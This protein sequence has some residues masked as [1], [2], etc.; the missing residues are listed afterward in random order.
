MN[1]SFESNNHALTSV[2]KYKIKKSMHNHVL[3]NCQRSS[4]SDGIVG[5]NHNAIKLS[6]HVINSSALTSRPYHASAS[7]RTEV[8]AGSSVL[9]PTGED[10]GLEMPHHDQGIGI[11]NFLRGKTFLV[12]GA[13]GFF[14]KVLIEKILRTAPDV[15]KIFVVIRAKDK[16]SAV[17]RLK[18]EVH[19]IKVYTPT[20]FNVIS[21][22]FLTIS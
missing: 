10:F 20:Y 12:T 9:S 17:E 5:I 2:S 4:S 15:H 6:R 14:A 1:I 11:V 8:G 21:F 19:I 7:P 16:A 22:S 3:Y 18:N 13:T